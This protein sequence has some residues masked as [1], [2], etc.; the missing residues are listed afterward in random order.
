M[1]GGAQMKRAKVYGSCRGALVNA[2]P[3]YP[4]LLIEN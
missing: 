4:L 2:E 3:I 1:I